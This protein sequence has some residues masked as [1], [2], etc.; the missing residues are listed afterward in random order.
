VDVPVDPADAALLEGAELVVPEPPLPLDEEVPVVVWRDGS[1]GAILSIWHDPDDD[2]EPFAQDITI[3][4]L[5]EGAW[6]LAE[7]GRL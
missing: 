4:E 2:E 6:V 7:H 3:F 1:V 5:V